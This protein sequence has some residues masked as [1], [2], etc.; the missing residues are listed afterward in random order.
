MVFDIVQTESNI[1]AKYEVRK[2]NSVIGFAE[3]RNNFIHGGTFVFDILG[4]TYEMVYEPLQQI[5]SW[6]RRAKEKTDVP[7]TVHENGELFG[8]ISI[9]RS[10]GGLLKRYEYYSLETRSE[11]YDMYEIGLGKDGLKYPIYCGERQIALIEKDV[12]VYNNLDFY[13]ISTSDDNAAI[14]ATIFGMYLDASSYAHRGEFV[15]KSVETT[16]YLTTNSE[17]K[18]K[19]D[20]N[21]VSSINRE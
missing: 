13:H 2:G 8:R 16:Y 11:A 5:G 18:A 20:K 21:F 4:R 1:S 6:L 17:L 15:K 10:N 3:L 14:I 19:Y 7:Y 9:K 12:T